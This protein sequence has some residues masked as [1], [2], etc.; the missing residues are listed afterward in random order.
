VLCFHVAFSSIV[1][2]DTRKGDGELMVNVSRESDMSNSPM[3]GEHAVETS[4]AGA[5]DMKLEIVTIPVSDV[6]RAK[7]F[8]CDKVTR[9]TLRSAILTVT[10]GC[11]RR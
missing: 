11:C 2:S 6:D 9:R 8:R 1:F 4:G 3:H 5:F 7:R 10:A